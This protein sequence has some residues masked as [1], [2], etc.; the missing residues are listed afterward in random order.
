VINVIE[1]TAPAARP[2]VMEMEKL[3]MNVLHVPTL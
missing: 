3:E 1:L 2:L